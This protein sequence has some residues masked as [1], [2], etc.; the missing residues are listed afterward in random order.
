MPFF[1]QLLIL[2]LGVEFCEFLAVLL[3]FAGMLVVGDIA[4]SG[5]RLNFNLCREFVNLPLQGVFLIQQGGN[6]I[7]VIGY[8]L[9][10]ARLAL[11]V[12]L[13]FFIY[14]PLQEVFPQLFHGIGGDFLPAGRADF[15]AGVP[16]GILR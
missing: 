4:I 2:I 13:G 14:Q 11:G 5:G 12:Y 6:L 10:A 7:L 15:F 8:G 3:V 16:T 9:L 1:L